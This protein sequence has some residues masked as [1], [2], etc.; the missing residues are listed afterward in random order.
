MLH[1]ALD[2]R[3]TPQQAVALHDA[4]MAT[5]G[6]RSE[7]TFL[8]T[9]LIART[10]QRWPQWFGAAGRGA[11]RAY[12]QRRW[13]HKLK[14]MLDQGAKARPEPFVRTRLHPAIHLYSAGG[15]RAGKT[16]VLGFTG[17]SA[18]LL[19]P[20]SVFLQHLDARTT[21]L[22]LIRYPAGQGF[23]RGIPGLA[24]GFGAS[25]ERLRTL[26]RIDEYAASVTL[27]T[28][29]GGLA[30][31]MTAMQLGAAA[32][33][34]VGGRGPDEPRWREALGTSVGAVL[35]EH[36]R[37]LAGP[38]HVFLVFGRDHAADKAAAEAMAR[39]VPA[40]LVE[41]VDPRG[42]VGHN[43]LLPPLL[44]GEL[45]TLLESTVLDRRG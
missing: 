17:S 33:M 42:K 36:A 15:D 6:W 29:G 30:A 16:V 4:L 8:P 43:A 21:D 34:S 2:N 40:R 22:V 41:I 12:E 44:R 7:W 13:L 38:P 25:V 9:K 39:V 28:S 26:I 18:R 19:M 10:R 20:T 5:R 32:A 23:S 27:G 14:A 24:G 45:R 37:Q 35:Q 1:I 11:Q 31:L 3:M